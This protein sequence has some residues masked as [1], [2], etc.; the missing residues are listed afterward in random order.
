MVVASSLPKTATTPPVFNSVEAITLPASS[1]NFVEE[2]TAT[3]TCPWG[4]SRVS[5]VEVRETMR[6][7]TSGGQEGAPGGPPSFQG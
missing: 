2:S 6:P 1:M 5:S 7:I 3:V 4:V